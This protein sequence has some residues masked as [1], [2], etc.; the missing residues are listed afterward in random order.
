MGIVQNL[1]IRGEDGQI[2]DAGGRHDEPV[3][4]VFMNIGKPGCSRFFFLG[5][6]E[7]HDPAH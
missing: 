6:L 3:G 7:V 1:V 4:R 2:I 5:M